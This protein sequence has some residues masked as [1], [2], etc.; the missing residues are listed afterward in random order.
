MYIKQQLLQ[1]SFP[2]SKRSLEFKNIL[3]QIC[4]SSIKIKLKIYKQV[5]IER[6]IENAFVSF[7]EVFNKFWYRVASYRRK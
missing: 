4:R 3:K 1:K 7:R 2:K 6:H 5:Y